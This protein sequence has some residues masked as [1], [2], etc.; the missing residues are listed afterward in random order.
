MAK[1][2]NPEDKN[3][4]QP[5]SFEEVTSPSGNRVLIPKCNLIFRKWEGTPIENTY[6]NKTV[7]DFDGQPLFAELAILKILQKEGWNGV[8]V[9][10]YRSKYRID[11]PEKGTVVELPNIQEEFIQNIKSRTGKRGGCWD[12]FVWKDGEYKFAESKRSK[13]DELRSNQLLWLQETLKLGLKLESFLL[14]EW[15][16]GS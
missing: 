11:L 14:V 15:D 13:K 9:D 1:T 3:S 7:I 2:Q 8:W 12:V 16:L 5:I 6:N 4:L 10:S